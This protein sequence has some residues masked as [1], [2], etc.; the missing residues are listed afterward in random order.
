[1]GLGSIGTRHL[2]NLLRL[3]GHDLLV[4]DPRANE[5]GFTIVPHVARTADLEKVWYFSP[6][7]VLICTPPATHYALA[8]E[9]LFRRINTFIEKPMTLTAFEANDLVSLNDD[10]KTLAVGFQL[11]AT[12]AVRAFPKDWRRLDIWDRQNMATWPTPTYQRQ[13]LTEFS[14]ELSLALFWAGA[15]PTHFQIDWRTT[16]HCVITLNWSD[17]RTA[18]IDLD[19]ECLTY[20][21]GAKADQATWTFSKDDNDEA[22]MAELEAFLAGAPSCT[23]WHGR[24]VMHCIEMLTGEVTWIMSNA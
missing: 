12:P 13:F 20:E 7:Y 11:L 19:G 3:G 23:G 2:R 17:Q 4:Y 14:H 6:D 5:I 21:R 15:M 22:Y 18:T 1:M 9:A 16:A 24:D 8:Y 10:Y